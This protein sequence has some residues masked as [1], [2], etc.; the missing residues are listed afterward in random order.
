ME[1]KGDV[2]GCKYHNFLPSSVS[3]TKN[4]IFGILMSRTIDWYINVSILRGS[5][6]GGVQG[7]RGIFWGSP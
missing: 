4:Y 6:G 2:R 3:S 7:G 1:I 5:G